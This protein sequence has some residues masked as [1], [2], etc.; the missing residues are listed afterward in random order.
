MSNEERFLF[1]GVTDD[2]SSTIGVMGFD[3]TMST[4]YYQM[5]DPFPECTPG[6]SLG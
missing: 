6:A 3:F 1:S 5:T 2:F 4:F